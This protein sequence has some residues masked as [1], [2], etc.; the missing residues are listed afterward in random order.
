MKNLLKSLGMAAVVAI[1]SSNVNAATLVCSGTVTELAYHAP[2]VLYV[3]L[4]GMNTFVGICST[5]ANWGPP[6]SLS[7][8]TTPAACKTIYGTLLFAKQAGT[9]V[10]SM[11]FDRDELPAS[12]SAFTSWTNVNLRFVHFL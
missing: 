10:S 7:G 12:C 2:G 6:G 9:V 11:Y 3:R 8:N 5:D 4:S 1:S